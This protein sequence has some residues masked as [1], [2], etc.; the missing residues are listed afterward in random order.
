MHEGDAIRDYIKKVVPNIYANRKN[1]VDVLVKASPLDI[2]ISASLLDLY[3]FIESFYNASTE[4]E[5]I[6]Q[7]K[8]EFQDYIITKFDEYL[9]SNSQELGHLGGAPTH[10]GSINVSIST[11]ISISSAI[12]DGH[13]MNMFVGGDI[14]PNFGSRVTHHHLTTRILPLYK[15]LEHFYREESNAIDKEKIFNVVK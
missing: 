10:G 1:T 2:A 9:D 13:D 5:Q 4:Y 11:N 12:P 15:F 14:N 3:Y 6:K 7:A 8:A